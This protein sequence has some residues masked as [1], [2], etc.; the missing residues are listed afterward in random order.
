MEVTITTRHCDISDQTKG[1][2]DREING[3]EKYYNRII[4]AD[5]TLTAEKHRQIAEIRMKINNGTIFGKSE[6]ADLRTSFD[7]AV[8]KLVVQLKK[9]KSSRMAKRG[10][11][12]RE[13]LF[14]GNVQEADEEE[15]FLEE[16]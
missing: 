14:T 9:A 1:Y 2:I 4:G 7:Q 13:M 10:A 3:L 12:D 5:V 11:R 16:D 8:E 6:S 15:E